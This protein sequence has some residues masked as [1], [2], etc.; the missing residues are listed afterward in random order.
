MVTISKVLIILG[1]FL[2]MTDGFTLPILK[3][4]YDIETIDVE[5]REVQKNAA[6]K[7]PSV[8]HFA[9]HGL[10]RTLTG[11]RLL[12]KALK[13][14]LCAM[15]RMFAQNIVMDLC[16]HRNRMLDLWVAEVF[17]LNDDGF[18]SHFERHLYDIDK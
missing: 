1:T 12:Y 11:K 9:R 18:I 17:D 15:T 5:Q 14:K 10:C 7:Y 3:D 13:T 4:N 8:H 2:S 16:R 6:D